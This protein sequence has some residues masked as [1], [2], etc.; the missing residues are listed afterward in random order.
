MKGVKLYNNYT[1]IEVVELYISLERTCPNQR[2][3]STL[4]VM[5]IRD[6]KSKENYYVFA[7]IFTYVAIFFFS[8][9]YFIFGVP[10]SYERE[11]LEPAF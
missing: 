9:N 2:R 8:L 7:N 10:T 1:A 11:R 5:A 3:E 6:E 4:R